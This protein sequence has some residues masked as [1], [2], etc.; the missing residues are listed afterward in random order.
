MIMT[1]EK[2]QRW[3][4]GRRGALYCSPGCGGKCT[5][6]DYQLARK[7]GHT[8]VKTL[9]AKLGDGWGISV[10]E[11]MGWRYTVGRGGVS[12]HVSHST[13]GTAT[14]YFALLGEPG[15]SGGLSDWT[16]HSSYDDPVEAVQRTIEKAEKV[17]AKWQQ[18]INTA[19][20]VSNG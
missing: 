14:S 8:L 13:I 17:M 7:R 18:W 16:D 1:S 5:W 15:G 20:G 2:Q 6:A 3:S 10:F 12:V 11:S 4:P 19:K 9:T